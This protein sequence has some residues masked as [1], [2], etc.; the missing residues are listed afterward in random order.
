MH[1]VTGFEQVQGDHIRQSE[2]CASCHTLITE[3]L[4][5]DGRVIGS[6]PEQ[7][8]YQEWRHSAFAG[9]GRSCQSCHMPEV[10]GPV[11]V[12]SVLGNDR[13]RMGR[14]AFIGGNA[15]MLR[16]MNRHRADLGIAAPVGGARGHGGRDRSTTRAR[17][18]DRRGRARGAVRRHAGARRRGDESDR[19]QA[20]DRIS[21]ATRVAARHR[22]R[23][24]RAGALR[25]R[26]RG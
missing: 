24:R 12:S 20:A 11:R 25:V 19:P 6:L 5:P 1:S 21:V 26:A 2:F 23:R 13:E 9:E 18:G 8:N 10:A 22:P 15:F 4:G 7:M 3:A 16:L 14:H 17:H